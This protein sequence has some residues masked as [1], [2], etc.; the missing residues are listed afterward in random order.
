MPYM[1][2]DVKKLAKPFLEHI[3]VILGKN[4]ESTCATYKTTFLG[5]LKVE[6]NREQSSQ[7]GLSICRK[8]T[9]IES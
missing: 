7:R 5:E 3:C 2:M 8:R 4:G 6:K 1:S 9:T